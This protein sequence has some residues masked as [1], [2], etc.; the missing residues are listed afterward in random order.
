MPPR[1][2]RTDV[3]SRKIFLYSPAMFRVILAS[4]LLLPACSGCASC[5]FSLFG[6]SYS[7][8]GP[9][10]E[11]KEHDYDANVEASK[12]YAEANRKTSDGDSSPWQATA[13]HD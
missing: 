2:G 13:L 3:D 12:A 9:S 10:R 6:D 1:R 7:A 5:L 8:A 4:C 11:D